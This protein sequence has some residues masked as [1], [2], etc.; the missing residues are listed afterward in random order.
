MSQSDTLWE[1]LCVRDWRLRDLGDDDDGAAGGVS[2]YKKMYRR[3]YQLQAVSCR[4]LSVSDPDVYPGP[5]ASHSLNFVSGSLL[6]LFGG[7][8]DGG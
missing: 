2:K 7:G 5:R 4:G 6:F 3:V 8:S 1:S